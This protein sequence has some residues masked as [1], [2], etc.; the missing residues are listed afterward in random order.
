MAPSL[1]GMNLDVIKQIHIPGAYREHRYAVYARPQGRARVP[2]F[3][4]LDFCRVQPSVVAAQARARLAGHSSGD[5]PP[6]ACSREERGWQ[7]RTALAGLFVCPLVGLDGGQSSLGAADGRIQRRERSGAL[8]FGLRRAPAPSSARSCEYR[9]CASGLGH[10]GLATGQSSGGDRIRAVRVWQ[11]PAPV[12]RHYGTGAADRLPPR[13]RH[14]AWHCP[15]GLPGGDEVEKP[16]LPTSSSSHRESQGGVRPCQRLPFVCQDQARKRPGAE[17]DPQSQQA[18]HHQQPTG[19]QTRGGG[20]QQ[21]CALSGSKV[22]ADGS[23]QWGVTTADQAVDEDRQSSPPEDTAPRDYPRAGNREEERGQESGIRP[24]VADQPDHRGIYLWQ[25]SGRACRRE[26]DAARG[27]AE[28]SRGVWGAGQ[29]GDGSLRPRREL[30][31]DRGEAAKGRCQEGRHPASRKSPL[32]CCRGRP[33]R[34]WQPTREDRGEHR[35][36]KE[37]QVRIQRRQTAQ[38]RE[39][40]RSRAAC[41]GLYEFGQSD[42]RHRRERQEDDNRRCLGRQK[43]S[44][45]ELETRTQQGAKGEFDH[46]LSYATRSNYKRAASESFP[47]APCL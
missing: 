22:E 1:A 26:K 14:P 19:D 8:V 41:D 7:T 9:P 38:Q 31:G 27:L 16:W 43:E 6:L 24:E 46:F 13:G 28:L 21:D 17:E 40:A 47:L 11:A 3:S 25:S 32:V 30:H 44:K 45:Q 23:S 10:G 2:I 34:G 12:I 37:Q 5:G 20:K 39:P 33:E 4:G 42:E 15:A 18:T 29:P 36:P 35:D